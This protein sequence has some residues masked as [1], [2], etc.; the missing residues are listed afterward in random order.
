VNAMWGFGGV[1]VT[2][3]KTASRPDWRELRGAACVAPGP[4]PFRPPLQAAPSVEPLHRVHR[5]PVALTLSS[6]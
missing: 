4:Q 5:A 1:R 3:G 6:S 2:I